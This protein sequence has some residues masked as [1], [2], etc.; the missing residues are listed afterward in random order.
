MS[1][2]ELNGQYKERLC[3]LTEPLL[4][5]YRKNRREL[6][7]RSDTDPYHI[8]VSEIMLPQ[9]RVEAVRPYYERFLAA[10]PDV[11][12]LA[13][14][15]EEVLLKLWEGLGYYS[16]ARNLKRAAKIIVEK[17]D[18]A[19]PSTYEEIISLPGIGSYTAGAVSSIAF[20][21]PRP[22]VDGNV[23]RVLARLNADDTDILL[24][25]AK[26]SAEELL[27]E[28]IPREEPGL[29]NQAMME[30]G[31]VICLPNGG[32]KCGECPLSPF[33][34]AHSLGREKELPVRLKKGKRK[35]EERTVLLIR[36]GD[37]TAV[38][39]RPEKGLLAG[40]YEFPALAGYPDEREI[41]TAVAAMGLTPLRILR[42]EDAKHIF[43]HVEWHMRA[44]EIRIAQPRPSDCGLIF[45]DEDGMR[46]RYAIPSA[47][48]AYVKCLYP[49][50]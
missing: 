23:L 1:K 44:Y 18:G 38:R 3:A 21:L 46:G 10:L 12:S 28:V 41:L 6:P 16:R 40:M 48:R 42:R 39:K 49:D 9:T 5:W 29:F 27:A 26:R 25:E 2:A 33:C 17:F 11:A 43:S 4:L 36:D 31:A 45:A 32:P 34:L 19:F 37:L 8:W 7:W 20:G 15:D 24:P 35:I 22:A 47:L 13:G 14:C 50:L 30:I